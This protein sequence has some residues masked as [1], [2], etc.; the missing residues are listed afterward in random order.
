MKPSKVEI[1]KIRTVINYQYRNKIQEINKAIP[2][3]I[4]ITKSNKTKRIKKI[5][6]QD[7]DAFYFRPMDG[8][9]IPSK[10][11]A[12]ILN[13]HL[14]PGYFRVIIN[15]EAEPFIRKGKTAFA[16]HVISADIEIRIGDEILILNEK[17]DLIGWGN[18]VLPG[19]LMKE[20]NSG[21]AIKTRGGIMN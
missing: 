1:K 20:M 2:E 8:L 18:A 19:K 17:K 14:K 21:V 12:I 9:F 5:I 15:N 4:E 13:S 6:I 3:T 7:K 10:V 16:K 11:G